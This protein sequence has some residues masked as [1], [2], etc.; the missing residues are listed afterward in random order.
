MSPGL[1]SITTQTLDKTPQSTD[2]W[3]V[4]ATSHMAC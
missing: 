1:E 3:L 4:A 2:C